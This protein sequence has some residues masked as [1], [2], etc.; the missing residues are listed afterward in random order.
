VHAHDVSR[1]DLED[2]RRG[3]VEGRG[4]H[5]GRCYGAVPMFELEQLVCAAHI[6]G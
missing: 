1:T 3:Q 6:S 2:R 4:D 5:G